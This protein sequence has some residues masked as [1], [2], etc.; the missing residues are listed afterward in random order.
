MPLKKGSSNKAVSSNISELVQTGRPQK[1]A[2]A[3]AMSVAGRSKHKPGN[4]H[5]KKPGNPHPSKERPAHH[6]NK[7]EM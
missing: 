6:R 3:I 4:P 5:G 2:V 7:T 1:Q